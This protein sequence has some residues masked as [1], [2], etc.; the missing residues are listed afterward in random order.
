MPVLRFQDEINEVEALNFCYASY[1][2]ETNSAYGNLA[3]LGYRAYIRNLKFG[4]KEPDF[5]FFFPDLS[6]KEIFI[7]MI[8]VK[9]GRVQEK[10]VREQA[11]A[12][13]K[14]DK[15]R[16]K[17]TFKRVSKNYEPL[18]R[19][20]AYEA[21]EFS[22]IFQYY[23]DVLSNCGNPE[24][25]ILDELNRHVHVTSCKKGDKTCSWGGVP[26]KN[27]PT[28]ALFQTGIKMPYVAADRKL[29]PDNPGE[30]FVAFCIA[31]HV[32]NTN[33]L[34]EIPE[35]TAFQ[36]K[37]DEFIY[38]DPTLARIET[39]LGKMRR[40]GLCVKKQ[41]DD[42]SAQ[43]VF[44]FPAATLLPKELIDPLKEGQTLDEM[45]KEKKKG[46]EFS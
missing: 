19:F 1:F 22:V 29:M 41:M 15:V 31:R 18:Q 42:K 3:N 13:S 2:S 17:D 5:S 40:L 11:T 23:E 28:T 44:S 25:G 34:T 38:P 36:L 20:A 45:L 43:Q 27:I 33:F 14:L 16:V 10:H 26:L 39:V 7:L 37:N 21:V 46:F 32:L 8:E 35:V 24:S 4:P 30:E 12:Y 6:T 9:S